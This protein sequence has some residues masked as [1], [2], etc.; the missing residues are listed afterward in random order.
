[1]KTAIS[2]LGSTAD[3]QSLCQPH[4]AEIEAAVVV[5]LSA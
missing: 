1:M 3:R 5:G 4:L 2:T